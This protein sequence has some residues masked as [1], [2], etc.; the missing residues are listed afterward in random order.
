MVAF[1]DPDRNASDGA[2]PV[3]S[4]A[5]F[6]EVVAALGLTRLSNTYPVR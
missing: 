5:P 4:R 1:A 6:G 2:A 3:L